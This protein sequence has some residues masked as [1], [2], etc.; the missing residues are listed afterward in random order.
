MGTYP[1]AKEQVLCFLIFQ[2]SELPSL[3]S[4]KHHQW[5]LSCSWKHYVFWYRW[6]TVPI[7]T[8]NK[9]EIKK[10]CSMLA[11]IHKSHT[12][13]SVSCSVGKQK[14]MKM[15]HAESTRHKCTNAHNSPCI[16]PPWSSGF[17]Q[18]QKLLI[19]HCNSGSSGSHSYINWKFRLIHQFSTKI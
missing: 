18:Q 10:T 5:S 16:L 13:Q 17:H 11:H 7:F 19:N 2:N 9:K 6:F 3:C 4:G 15:L 8:N 12:D 1:L 14:W